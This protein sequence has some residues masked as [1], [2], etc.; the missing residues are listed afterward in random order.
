MMQIFDPPS[1]WMQ[2]KQLF[3]H[4]FSRWEKLTFN[5]A[6]KL[7]HPAHL[8]GGRWRMAVSILQTL[9]ANSSR[10]HSAAWLWVLGSAQAFTASDLSG[11]KKGARIL[12]LLFKARKMAGMAAVLIILPLPSVATYNNSSQHVSNQLTRRIWISTTRRSHHWFLK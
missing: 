9:Q 4:C 2:W 3:A 7:E 6:R 12:P 1:P 10:T 5:L 8:T 11:M